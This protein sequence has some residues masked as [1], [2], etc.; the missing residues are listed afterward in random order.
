MKQR[1]VTTHDA[2]ST[3]RSALAFALAMATALLLGV[4]LGPGVKASPASSVHAASSAM[5]QA[6]DLPERAADPD[7]RLYDRA[8]L[9]TAKQEASIETDLRR[10]SGLG[11]E[12][13]VY[14][15]ISGDTEEESQAHA[16]RLGA[17]WAVESSAG[18][19]DGLVFLI[20]ATPTNPD[21]NS[22]V[23]ATGENAMPIRQLDAAGLQ[24]LLETEIQPEFEDEDFD[25]AILTGL[26]RVL[27][28]MEYT[29][30][31]SEPLSTLQESLN[32]TAN[33]LAAVLLQGV[34][35][36]YVV[37]GV[38]RDK[39]LTVLPSAGALAIYATWVSVAAVMIGVI[40]IAGRSAFGSL[41]AVGALVF[42]A[43]VIP[44]VIGSTS[45][46]QREDRTVRVGWRAP[47]RTHVIGR[48]HD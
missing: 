1:P 8:D 20:T 41:T 21:A 35:L 29:P 34:V 37:V 47:R 31:E 36:G 7:I 15:R 12:M 25:A 23:I 4:G 14:T 13:L 26:R 2:T 16:E 42:A 5:R 9:F 38:I 19:N 32:K 27:Y 48:A 24:S 30:P 39:R 22:I 28:F 17:E 44:L 43:C 3:G 11:V 46:R 45:N 10:A 18:A 40:A 6:A 33:I